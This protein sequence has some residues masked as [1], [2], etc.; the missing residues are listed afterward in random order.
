MTLKLGIVGCGLV[1]QAHANALKSCDARLAWVYDV[2]PASAAA[3]AAKS[4]ASAV[5]SI[6]QLIDARPDGVI[7]CTPPAYHA[8]S[9][10]PF[11]DARV[12]VLCE[13]PLAQD[14]SAAAALAQAV[15]RSGSL[16]MVAFTQRFHPAVIELRRLVADG[17]IGE[18]HLLHNMF[19]GWVPVTQSHRADPRASGGGA[20]IDNGIH[21]IDLFRILV[22]EP[23][24]VQAMMGNIAQPAAAEDLG[25][26]QLQAPGPCFGQIVSTYSLPTCANRIEVYGS[27]GVASVQ[28]GAPRMP[29]LSY[30]HE[31]QPLVEVD[32]SKHPERRVGQLQAF[33]QS[34]RSG[35]SAVPAA[36]GLAASRIIQAAY[37]SAR[38][39]RTLCLEPVT[40]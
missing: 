33:F 38:Q 16:F 35:V 14:Q 27:K 5:A 40:A 6:E 7:I 20:M 9:V 18:V 19:G 39:Q 32:C 24:A 22:G 13:K 1:A 26:I 11:L 17:V 21:S 23:I 36:E 15:Q 8:A 30:Q 34:I 2:K 31:D 3:L 25:V 29:L 4:G 12:P 10:Q 28:Y 37:D